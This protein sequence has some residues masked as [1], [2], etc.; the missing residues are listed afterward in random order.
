MSRSLKDEER[1]AIAFLLDEMSSLI[2]EEA[3]CSESAGQMYHAFQA[4]LKAI[5]EAAIQYAQ[6]NGPSP[7][8]EM[9]KSRGWIVRDLLRGG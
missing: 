4:A 2:E 3:D 7:E 1:E 8:T 5:A 9:I 6:D